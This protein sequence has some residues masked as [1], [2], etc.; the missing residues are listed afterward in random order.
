MPGA[1][2][3]GPE[4][5]PSTVSSPCAA[6]AASIRSTVVGRDRVEVGDERPCVAGCGGDRL[7]HLDRRAGRHDA[8]HDVRLADERLQRPDVLDSRLAGEASRPFAATVER[9]DHAHAA[10][11]EPRADR[12]PHRPASDEPDDQRAREDSNLRPAD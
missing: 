8:E 6:S 9:D 1:C 4:I 11:P 2:G 10:V 12:A 7:G 5:E 3:G